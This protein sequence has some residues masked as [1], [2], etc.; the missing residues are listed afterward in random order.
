[1]F[2]HSTYFASIE[3]EVCLVFT[4]VT[5]PLRPVHPTSPNHSITAVST[6]THLPSIIHHSIDSVS[7]AEPF[8]MMLPLFGWTVSLQQ[9]LARLQPTFSSLLSYRC[10]QASTMDWRPPPPF[11]QLPHLSAHP[12]ECFEPSFAHNFLALLFLIAQLSATGCSCK[13]VKSA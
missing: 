11:L 7:S 4:A 10:F 5:Q 12:A 1:M 8:H 6:Q 9:R 13:K 2:H 3:I